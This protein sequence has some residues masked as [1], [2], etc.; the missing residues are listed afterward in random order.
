[1]KLKSSTVSAVVPTIIARLT[2][3]KRKGKGDMRK[4]CPASLSRLLPR[5]HHKFGFLSLSRTP[6]DFIRDTL[7]TNERLYRRD[8]ASNCLVCSLHASASGLSK[9]PDGSE[10]WTRNAVLQEI[11]DVLVESVFLRFSH[12]ACSCLDTITSSEIHLTA[13][14]LIFITC[15]FFFNTTHTPADKLPLTRQKLSRHVFR[16]LLNFY[17]TASNLTFVSS[18]V[19]R[20]YLLFLLFSLISL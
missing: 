15:F 9:R 4:I 14:G 8:S 16:V 18:S 20:F 11:V 7:Y 17:S 3:T 13:F 6:S 2:R 12:L 19:V 1:M 10:N 5:L